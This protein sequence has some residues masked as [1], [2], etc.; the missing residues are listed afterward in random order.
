[1]Q[2]NF[3]KF[4]WDFNILKQLTHVTMLNPHETDPRGDICLRL[5]IT[6]NIPIKMSRYHLNV[7]NPQHYHESFIFVSTKSFLFAFPVLS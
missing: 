2:L 1:M 6:L 4:M 3:A 7:S 5:T